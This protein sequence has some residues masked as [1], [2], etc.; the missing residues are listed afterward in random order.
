M[1][2]IHALGACLAGVFAVT[3][4]AV[5]AWS[6]EAT[7]NIS[8]PQRAVVMTGEGEIMAM[9]DQA[10]ISAGAVTQAKTA[11]EA[12][13]ENSAIMSRAFDAL[14][15]LG[16]SKA[17]TA[18]SGFSLD[19]QYPPQSDKNPQPRVIIGY[20]V[21]NSIS[22]TLDDV[23]RAGAVLDALIEAGAN[24]SAGVTFSIKNQ[25]PLL[26][27]ARA[28]AARDA[29]NRAQIY[30]RNVGAT[31]GAVR[32]IREGYV[33]PSTNQVE[34]VVVTASR[35]ATPIAAGEQSVS[36]TVTVEWAIK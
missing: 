19:P 33:S 23:A 20:E 6:A 35:A 22:V 14:K 31:L 5:P 29:L 15:G 2:T 30:S 8:E 18:T 1:K 13:A 28:L 24:Q 27:Q 26:D 32:S 3:V 10:V 25:Q 11:S 16:V 9:P 7:L 17:K 4:G 21:S 34:S 12:V 36:A